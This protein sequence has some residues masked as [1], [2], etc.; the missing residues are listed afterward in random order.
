MA[1]TSLMRWATEAVASLPSRVIM[2]RFG[3]VGLLGYGARCEIVGSFSILVG[4]FILANIW[5]HQS[6]K[7]QARSWLVFS[8]ASA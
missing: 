5:N 6:N 7:L 3:M 1:I 4:N 8:G 2:E